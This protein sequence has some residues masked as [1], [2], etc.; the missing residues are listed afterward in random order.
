MERQAFCA[1]QAPRSAS[2]GRTFFAELLVLRRGLAGR[3]LR[4]LAKGG[5]FEIAQVQA[6]VRRI[7]A[8]YAPHMPEWNSCLRGIHA[9]QIRE[10]RDVRGSEPEGISYPRFLRCCGVAAQREQLA[11]HSLQSA[12]VFKHF[13]QG[14]QVRKSRLEMSMPRGRKDGRMEGVVVHRAALPEVS[15]VGRIKFIRTNNTN[16]GEQEA[17]GSRVI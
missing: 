8:A 10:T 5:Q 13:F 16:S 17:P 2:A 3:A 11:L 7:C 12:P 14:R 15:W 1:L 6:Q 9:M 4:G